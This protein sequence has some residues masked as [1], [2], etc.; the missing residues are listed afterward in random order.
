MQWG[1]FILICIKSMSRQILKQKGGGGEAQEGDVCLSIYHSHVY[2][3][4]VEISTQNSQSEP[5]QKNP[6]R[7]ETLK[8]TC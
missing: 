1:S 3:T 4:C 6:V 2:P 5:P 8:H 7:P